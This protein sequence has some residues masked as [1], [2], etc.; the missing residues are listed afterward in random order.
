MP[1]GTASAARRDVW[2]TS[3]RDRCHA[4]LYLP[5]ASTGGH[6]DT[7][8]PS[9]PPVIVMAHGLG[10][11]KTL[12]LAGFAERF[13]AAGYACLVFDYRHFGDSE[14]Q[15]R[16]LL[17]IRRQR[18]DWRAAVAFSRTLPEVDGARVV[19]W[20]TS[21]AGGHALVT[22]AQDPRVAAVVV[23][24]PFTDGFASVTALSAGT[25]ARLLSA[26]GRDVA[27]ALLHRP[28]VRIKAAARPGELGLMSNAAD[29]ESVLALLEASGLS[30]ADFRN[31]VPARIAL[32]IPFARP[33]RKTR[34]L[35]CPVLFCVADQDGVAPANATL[36]HA[37]NAP[38][39]EIKTYAT[40][41]FD[42]YAGQWFEPVIADQLH[43]LARH[44]HPIPPD[45]RPCRPPHLDADPRATTNASDKPP[46]R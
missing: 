41:H 43:F 27:A 29:V 35:R 9:R 33:G 23:Q 28:P 45:A 38:R 15:P 40:G 25:V 4:W 34:D 44:V 20:G 31:D 46:G 11:V 2:F 30:E 17:S 32:T 26:A 18:Q 16:E 7:A 3:G 13:A 37:R 6:G 5:P 21:F 22:G 19:L 36:R 39:G 8:D 10:A 1:D 12:R 14:G 42:I 24:C